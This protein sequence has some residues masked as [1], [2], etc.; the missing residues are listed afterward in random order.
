MGLFD[1]FFGGKKADQPADT[2]NDTN[3]GSVNAPLNAGSD[4]PTDGTPTSDTPPVTTTTA[5][6]DTSV[7]INE[8][9]EFSAPQQPVPND[10]PAGP[11][12]TVP[13]DLVAAATGT[14]QVPAPE[15]TAPAEQPQA[16]TPVSDEEKTV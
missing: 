8:E 3:T 1:K 12:V 15:E 14:D 9:G 16:D 13:T 4:T 11:A 6:P 2:T 5:A 7:E 10:A